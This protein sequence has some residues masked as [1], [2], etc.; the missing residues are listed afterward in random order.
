METGTRYYKSKATDCQRDRH[1]HLEGWTAKENRQ[2]YSKDAIKK[3]LRNHLYERTPEVINEQIASKEQ[4]KEMQTALYHVVSQGL[5]RKAETERTTVAGKTG[6]AL[7]FTETNDDGKQAYNLS[8]CGYFP[9]E[10]PRYS[11]IVSLNKPRLPASGGGMAGPVFSK[12]VE[13]MID[14]EM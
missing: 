1:T 6:T 12:I 11:I 3:D 4:I 2:Y 9:A 8:F 13:Y 14:R 10:N 7:V 5:G